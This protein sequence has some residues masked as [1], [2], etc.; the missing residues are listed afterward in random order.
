[1]KKSLESWQEYVQKQKSCVS[2]I[3][4]ACLLIVSRDKDKREII[5][6]VSVGVIFSHSHSTQQFFVGVS[7]FTNSW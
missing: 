7:C 1:M 6:S 3:I 5:R 4:D 2:K